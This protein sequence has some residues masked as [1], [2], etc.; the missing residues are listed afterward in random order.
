MVGHRESKHD[1]ISHTEKGAPTHTT[2]ATD[3]RTMTMTSGNLLT[4]AGSSVPSQFFAF[5]GSTS[6]STAASSLEVSGTPKKGSPV[7][8]SAGASKDN[9]MD[10]LE[11]RG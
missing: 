1:S 4:E 10:V 11:K 7:L 6:N 2:T 3:E 5:G 8:S 9:D